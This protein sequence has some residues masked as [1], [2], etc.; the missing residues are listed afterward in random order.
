MC[1]SDPQGH[2]VIDVRDD[3]SLQRY[4]FGERTA[5]FLVCRRCGV[6]AGA[7]ITQDEAVRATS[8][9]RLTTLRDLPAQPASYQGETREE[10]IA[11][12]LARWTPARLVLRA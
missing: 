5:E 4:R 8:N 6:Y 11:R 9:L 7:M 2:V 1:W 10:R 3:G 12:R